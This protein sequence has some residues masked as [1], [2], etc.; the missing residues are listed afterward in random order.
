MGEY[1][2]Q[3]E[4]VNESPLYKKADEPH[5][6]YR[7]KTGKWMVAASRTSVDKEIGNFITQGTAHRLP[8]SEGVAWNFYDGDGKKWVPNGSLSVTDASVK[9]AEKKVATPTDSDKTVC[10]RMSCAGVCCARMSMCSVRDE[11]VC[12]KRDF[13]AL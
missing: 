2:L 8:T 12:I 9:A 11:L 13:V 10:A 5:Y 1:K 3:E 7:L 6:I 4:R